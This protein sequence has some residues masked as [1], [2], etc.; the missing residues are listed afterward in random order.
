MYEH[1]WQIFKRV[2]VSDVKLYGKKAL[3]FHKPSHF[4]IKFDKINQE[5]VYEAPSNLIPSASL[6]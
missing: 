5:Y 6:F 4:R 1:N 3:Q 2:K